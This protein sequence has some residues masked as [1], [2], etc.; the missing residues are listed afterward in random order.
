M[1]TEI[2]HSYALQA[3]LDYTQLIRQTYD[4]LPPEEQA[5]GEDPTSLTFPNKG[6]SVDLFLASAPNE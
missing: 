5:K 4:F 3:G 1:T 2:T 6:L